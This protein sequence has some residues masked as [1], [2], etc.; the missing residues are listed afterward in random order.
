MTKQM[1]D[2]ERKRAF[3]ADLYDAKRWKKRVARMS[4]DQVTAIFLRNQ[5]A[6]ESDQPE[7]D[8]EQFD[9]PESALP[10]PI[11]MHGPHQNEDDFPIY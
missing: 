7:P 9:L 1:T 8:N 6:D 11:H 5:K 4:D 10:H 2:A 3:V